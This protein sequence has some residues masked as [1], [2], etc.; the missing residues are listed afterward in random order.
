[1]SLADDIKK[2]R[3]EAKKQETEA[4]RL[5]NLAEAYPD[6]KK[7]TG[8]WSKIA[9]YSKSVNDKVTRFDI[10]HNCGCCNDS[11]LE[12]WPYLETPHG[13][14]YSDPPCFQVGERHWM[15]GDRP[16]AGWQQK[17]K[18]A[19]IPEIIIGAI[20][21]HFKQSRE[22]RIAAAS[23]DGDL[24]YSEGDDEPYI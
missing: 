22:N 12:I 6:L 20:G 9:Y 7:H 18:N 2:A 16:Y 17:M 19:G 23:E 1:M 21:V 14:V 5:A 3:E 8:R 4:S 10:R 24:D 15:G 11:P 13:N